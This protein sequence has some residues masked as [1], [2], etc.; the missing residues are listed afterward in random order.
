MT[1]R[2]ESRFDLP[3][4]ALYIHTERTTNQTSGRRCLPS[5]TMTPPKGKGKDFSRLGKPSPSPPA[6]EPVAA[7]TGEL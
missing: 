7:Q 2:D 1:P 5:P 3:P 6:P 4:R